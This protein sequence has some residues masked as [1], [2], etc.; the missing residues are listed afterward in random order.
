MIG[1]KVGIDD[2]EATFAYWKV[3]L[4][5]S[6]KSFRYGIKGKCREELQ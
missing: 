4:S 6:P 1:V 5:S 3:F 2:F